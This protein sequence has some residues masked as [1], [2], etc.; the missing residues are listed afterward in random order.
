VKKLLSVLVIGGLVALGC[1][2]AT[3]SGSKP[4]GVGSGS[5]PS[6]VAPTLKSSPTGSTGSPVKVPEKDT[7]ALPDKDKPAPKKDGSVSL[8]P[9][10]ASVTVEKGKKKTVSVAV[11]RTDY[12]GELALK[13]ESSSKD[14][15]I[16]V[17][18]KPAGPKDDKVDVDID[19]DATAKPGDYT[20][21]LTGTGKDVKDASAT[22]KVTVK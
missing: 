17:T 5:K 4:A 22:I 19:V 15:G 11:N 20:V 12:E 13:G 8:K 9:A 21:T 2:P 1:G 18:A 14:S 7:P 6:P 16:K 10:D 3:P